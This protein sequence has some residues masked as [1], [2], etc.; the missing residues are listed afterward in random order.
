MINKQAV[1]SIA[2]AFILG[3]CAI[4]SPRVEIPKWYLKLPVKKGFIY[5]V[6]TEKGDKIEN[7]VSEATMVAQQK[8]GSQMEME[9][10]A[11]AK[12]AQEEVQDIAAV[13]TFNNT[14]KTVMAKSLSDWTV[15]KQDIVPAGKQDGRA[16]YQAF[17]VIEWNETAAQ[18]RVLQQLKADEKLYQQFRSTDLLNELEK[19]VADYRKRRGY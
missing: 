11:N 18:E 16:M 15:Y 9:I 1:S 17:V 13:N 7:A 4:F 19:D 2:L 10:E 5:T 14:F 12:R 3:G 6:G 8:L